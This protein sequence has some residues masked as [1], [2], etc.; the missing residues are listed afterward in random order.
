MPNKVFSSVNVTDIVIAPWTTF[1]NTIIT[2]DN[3]NFTTNGS[4]STP[5]LDGDGFPNSSANV[6]RDTAVSG[7]LD[8]AALAPAYIPVDARI[9]RIT[10]TFKVSV[11][12]SV[13][14]PD[15]LYN[16]DAS[17]DFHFPDSVTPPGHPT[18]DYSAGFTSNP[19][20]GATGISDFEQLVTLDILFPNVPGGDDNRL[21]FDQ[22]ITQFSNMIIYINLSI[23]AVGEDGASAFGSI[24]S[25]EWTLKAY[26]DAAPISWYTKPKEIIF[27]GLPVKIPD[28]IIPIP[29]GEPIPEEFEEIGPE[30]IYYWWEIIEEEEEEKKE[31]EKEKERKEEIRKKFIKSPIPPGAKWGLYNGDGI[32]PPSC[33]GCMSIMLG[34][35]EILIANASGI[36]VL[37]PGKRTDTLY[38]RFDGSTVEVRIPEP[39]AKTGFV[40]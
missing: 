24:E 13:T 26:Y 37:Q 1:D 2:F 28:E 5:S 14:S 25:Q 33:V 30:V 20:P 34:E 8:Y 21:T 31:E 9:T 3:F 22:L 36:Y 19:A 7:R 11:N 40:S 27:S 16:L 29:E 23:G 35:L 17:V 18:L 32:G 4:H 39:S 12:A 6:Q 15:E 10:V 38:S